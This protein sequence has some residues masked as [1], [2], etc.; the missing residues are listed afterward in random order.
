MELDAELWPD[1]AAVQDGVLVIGGAR[2][3]ELAAEHGT[4]LVVY[5]RETIV[6]QARAFRAIDPEALVAFGVK[7][8]PNVAILRLLHGQGLGADVSTRGELEFALRAGLR[9]EGLFFHGN[10]KSDEEL[11]AAAA[12][13]AL[14]VLDSGE[15]VR[16]AARAGARR[17]LVRL[18]PGIKARTHQSIQTAHDD[19]KFGVDL[20]GAL[21]VLR[22]AR[23]LRPLRAE[24]LDERARELVRRRH[25]LV[26]RVPDPRPAAEVEELRRP[27]ELVE[28]AAAEGG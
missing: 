16:R 4:P 9:G 27:A 21:G 28:A 20:D 22:D 24:P 17:V 12:A 25:L 1:T 2:A 18:T 8:F 3:P 6:A 5:C 10:N 23:R 7:A 13:G 11:E 14:V 26:G 15:E 19:S